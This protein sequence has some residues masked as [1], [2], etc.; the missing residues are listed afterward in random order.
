MNHDWTRE[1]R[2][3]TLERIEALYGAEG[4]AEFRA[5]LDRL[6]KGPPRIG[7]ERA[8]F[9]IRSNPRYFPPAGPTQAEMGADSPPSPSQTP[10][11]QVSELLPWNG[12]PTHADFDSEV[13]WVYQQFPM[14][15]E[16][17]IGRQSVLHWARATQPPPN[18]A[19]IGLMRWAARN[20]TTFF[21][22]TV[23]RAF[24]DQN[25]EEDERVK[26]E[27]MKIGEIKEIL[28]RMLDAAHPE[29]PVAPSESI[30]RAG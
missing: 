14:V 28:A 3:K 27:K 23:P 1:P 6:A 29:V 24:K 19:A 7:K 4:V 25:S 10:A 18:A 26:R 17:A 8:W 15:V 12:L 11:P 30:R 20:E 5:E 13:R 21:K 16:E 22:E 2:Y 9:A